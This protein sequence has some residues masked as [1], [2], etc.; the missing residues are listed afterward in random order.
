MKSG[1]TITI[2]P[3]V[4]TRHPVILPREIVDEAKRAQLAEHH[5]RL[6]MDDEPVIAWP[7]VCVLIATV[8]TLVWALWR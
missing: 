6:A 5:R 7:A 8:L 4:T 3:Y 1:D 2:R